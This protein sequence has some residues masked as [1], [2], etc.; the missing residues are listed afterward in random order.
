MVPHV[1]VLGFERPLGARFA[2]G[3]HGLVADSAHG[4]EENL[5]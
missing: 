1:L 3:E 2:G 4:D 5:R